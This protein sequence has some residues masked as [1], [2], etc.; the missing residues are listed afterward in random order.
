TQTGPSDCGKRQ[1]KLLWNVRR[2]AITP[3]E[4]DWRSMNARFVAP[5]A[6][7]GVLDDQVARRRDA[8]LDLVWCTK[9]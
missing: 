3:Q 1:F 2:H 8:M 4:R 6:N 7:L 5:A 9:K